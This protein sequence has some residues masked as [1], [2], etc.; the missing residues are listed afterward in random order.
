[1]NTHVDKMDDEVDKSIAV[2][3]GLGDKGIEEAEYTH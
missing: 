3:G 2:I 1:M